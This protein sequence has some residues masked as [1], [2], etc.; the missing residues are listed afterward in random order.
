MMITDLEDTH[1]I[2]VYS[3]RDMVLVKGEGCTLFDEQGKAYLDCASN[4]GVSLLGYGNEEVARALYT[5]YMRLPTC[6]GIFYNDVRARLAQKLVAITP[7]GL[8]RVFFC[9]SG[10][11]AV[12]A[13]LKFARFTT[14]KPEI[15]CAMRGFHGKT[16]GAL[17][18]TWDLKYKKAMGPLPPG[19]VHIPFNNSEKLEAAVTA[20]TAAILLEVVQGEGGVRIGDPSFFNR[21]RALCDSW[22]I[23]LIID[24]VQTGFG[25]T[26][27][28]FGCEH[29]VT[30]D[31]LCLAKGIAGGVPM[32]AVVCKE[33]VHI[34]KNSHTS[35]FGGN[36]LTCAAALASIAVLEEQ[37]LV[38]KCAENGAYFL[39]SLRRLDSPLI[40]EI[41]GVG[42]MIGIELTEKAGPYIQALMEK[43]IIA[44]LAGKYVI[45]LLPP[46]IISREEIDR[47]VMTIGEVLQS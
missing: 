45:R 23:L 43:G 6:Y 17:G 19:Y 36:P 37:G 22:D 26:G 32:G 34:P 11:E 5:Q 25:R 2:D 12:E 24:E 38:R 3:R 20:R 7:Q 15:I 18:A 10:T 1:E 40:R 30:P 39:D 35:T 13:A 27:T 47:A 41:R 8:S 42:L 33:A 4:V 31:I 46:L 21:V 44:L 29:Y 14:Q 28:M 9:N 16:L